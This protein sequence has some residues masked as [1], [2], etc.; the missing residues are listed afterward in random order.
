MKAVFNGTVVA[1][2]DATEVVEGNH[3]FPPQSV[4]PEYFRPSEQYSV[5][6]WKG[7]A[8]Y[9]DVVVDG[10]VAKD[11]AWHYDD[12]KT[13]AENIRGHYAFWNGVTVED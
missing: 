5:C 6:P 2:S 10:E 8:S 11:A 13:R 1:E 12:P 9:N 4:K 3:Y 7:Q